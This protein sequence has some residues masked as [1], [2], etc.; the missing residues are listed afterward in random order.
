MQFCL[1]HFN[2]GMLSHDPSLEFICP[3]LPLFQR[4]WTTGKGTG[5]LEVI[6]IK[7]NDHGNTEVRSRPLV[8]LSACSL[9]TAYEVGYA[10]A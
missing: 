2:F 4:M 9:T 1:L 8:Q 10:F 3:L 5:F 6:A 7:Q